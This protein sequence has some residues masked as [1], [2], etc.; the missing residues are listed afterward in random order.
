MHYYDSKVLP[1][2]NLRHNFKI[3]SFT[4]KQNTVVP[5]HPR[6]PPPSRPPHPWTSKSTDIQVSCIKWRGSINPAKLVSK[7]GF[8]TAN[9]ANSVPIS[10]STTPKVGHVCESAFKAG[11][12]KCLS[13]Y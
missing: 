9:L 5:W 4:M 7:Q 12:S 11:T 8:M 1:S 6:D 10:A 2:P 3:K 13:P